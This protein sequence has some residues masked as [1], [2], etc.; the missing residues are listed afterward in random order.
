VNAATLPT[1]AEAPAG[2]TPSP[3]PAVVLTKP[4]AGRAWITLTSTHPDPVRKVRELARACFWA[5]PDAKVAITSVEPEP[6]DELRKFSPH[7]IY[8]VTAY[9]SAS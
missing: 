8:G 5:T 6:Y 2:L 3:W 7:V 4:V 1:L 9:V